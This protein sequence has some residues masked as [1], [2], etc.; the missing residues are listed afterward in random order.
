MAGNA[1]YMKKIDL[2][3]SLRASETLA[4]LSFLRYFAVFVVS[5]PGASSLNSHHPS[6]PPILRAN[7][8]SQTPTLLTRG[9]TNPGD[10]CIE[11]AAT[12]GWLALVSDSLCYTPRLR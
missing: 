5:G 2:K 10:G 12:L 4:L 8:S 3:S 11:D 1:S 6:Q 7:E 9:A